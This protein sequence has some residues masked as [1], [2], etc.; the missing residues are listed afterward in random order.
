MLGSSLG[1]VN[2][3]TILK[4]YTLVFQAKD[5]LGVWGKN[6]FTGF[7]TGDGIVKW[8][9]HLPLSVDE[10]LCSRRTW[11]K[12]SNLWMHEEFYASEDF[13]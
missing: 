1:P 2:I 5:S 6:F 11:E 3:G 7:S 12:T 10:F 9:R 13:K 8:P 4:H